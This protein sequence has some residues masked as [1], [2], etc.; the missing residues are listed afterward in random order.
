LPK[1]KDLPFE[2]RLSKEMINS[3]IDPGPGTKIWKDCSWV[4]EKDRF[5]SVY[6]EK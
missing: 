2:G 3:E 6:R 5:S 4:A 1:K